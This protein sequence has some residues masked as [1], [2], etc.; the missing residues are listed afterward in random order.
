MNAGMAAMLDKCENVKITT[1][2]DGTT[3]L[4]RSNIVVPENVTDVF[5]NDGDA[6]VLE[7]MTG[8][9]VMQYTSENLDEVSVIRSTYD[10]LIAVYVL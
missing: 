9:L 3:N 8:K 1:T 7:T 10:Q 5:A 4:N 2:S 6:L